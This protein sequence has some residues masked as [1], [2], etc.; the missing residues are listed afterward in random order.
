M[1][2]KVA[3]PI[4]SSRSS[5]PGVVAVTIGGLAR[6]AEVG[7]KTV[8]YY[9]RRRLLAVPQSGRGGAAESSFAANR[10]LP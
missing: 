7:V 8:R 1:P 9:Q 5:K 2:K 10:G 4:V 6:A 3:E